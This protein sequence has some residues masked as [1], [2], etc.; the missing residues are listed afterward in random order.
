MDEPERKQEDFE[1]NS[2]AD[3]VMGWDGMRGFW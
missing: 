3:G 1:M 2:E